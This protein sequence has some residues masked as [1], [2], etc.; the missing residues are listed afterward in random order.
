MYNEARLSDLTIPEGK[1]YLA[2]AGFEWGR[3]NVRPATKE[4]LYNL[5][6]ASARNVVE[7]RIPPAVAAV[8]NFILDHDPDDI[9]RYREAFSDIDVLP[10]TYGV[11]GT[12]PA[13]R[14]EI[15]RATIRRE[16]IAEDMWR[17]YQELTAA[18]N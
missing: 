1:Y 7:P 8:H 9:Y 15:M 11:L 5:R 10:G 14:P 13:R 4:E 6:H 2:D 12:G 3:A 17:N 18:N 16:G